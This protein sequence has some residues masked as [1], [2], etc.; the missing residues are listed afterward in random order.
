MKAEWSLGFTDA[1]I[2]KLKGE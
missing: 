2:K 1:L